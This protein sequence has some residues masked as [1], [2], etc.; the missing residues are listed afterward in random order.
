MTILRC[1]IARYG[2]T[3]RTVCVVA[4]SKHEDPVCVLLLD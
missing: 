1:V 3:C 2:L 4:G